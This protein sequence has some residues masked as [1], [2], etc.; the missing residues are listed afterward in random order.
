MKKENHVRWEKGVCCKL[1][2]FCCWVIIFFNLQIITSFMNF[3]H[4]IRFYKV[5]P[6]PSHPTPALLWSPS[7]WRWRHKSSRKVCGS[8]PP[9]QRWR[10]KRNMLNNR[11]IKKNNNTQPIKNMFCFV[12]F[13]VCVISLLL[14]AQRPTFCSPGHPLPVWTKVG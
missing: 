5:C 3:L 9:I 10:T 11:G 1:C 2:F 6:R 4:E 13:F 14:R 8:A 12:L 7:R